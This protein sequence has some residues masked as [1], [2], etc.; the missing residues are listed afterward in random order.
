MRRYIVSGILAALVSL[1]LATS[2][3]SACDGK[4]EHKG[5]VKAPITKKEDV[6]QLASAT[7]KVDGMHCEGCSDKVKT[8][9]NGTAGVVQ[10]DIKLADH[11]VAVQYDA[12]KLSP[13]KI[14]KII[15]DLGY[16]AAAQ[17]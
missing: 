16:K 10:V 2:T 14:A 5:N 17:A 3:A 12:T 15:S 4:D 11:T 1:S 7:F 8:A 13:E 9:L 6:K